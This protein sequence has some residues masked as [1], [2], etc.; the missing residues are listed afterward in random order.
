MRPD[1][2]DLDDELRGHLALSIE[3]RVARGEDPRQARLAA[4]AEL[5]YPP[6][7]RDSMRRVWYS[8]WYEMFDGLRRAARF[9]L[10]VLR[11]SPAF[12]LVAV[13]TLALAVGANAVVFGVMNGL[14]LRPLDVPH[15]ESLYGIEHAAQHNMY[16]SY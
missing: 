11:K 10:R 14:I 15:P 1:E 2:R 3:E 7:V 12:L 9:A 8:R 6:D 4:L 16:E 13:V 5:G